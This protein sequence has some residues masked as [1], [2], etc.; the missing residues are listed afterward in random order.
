MSEP[1]QKAWLSFSQATALHLAPAAVRETARAA[2]YAGATSLYGDLVQALAA[3]SNQPAR[4]LMQSVDKEAQSWLRDKE[5][6][7]VTRFP[8]RSLR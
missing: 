4:D 2:F 8:R 6:G 5:L 7:S 3:E 1:I